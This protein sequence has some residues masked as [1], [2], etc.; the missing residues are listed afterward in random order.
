MQGHHSP[1]HS[2]HSQFK[3]RHY[4]TKE[5]KDNLKD[6]LMAGASNW[7]LLQTCYVDYH[8]TDCIVLLCGCSNSL[9][10]A[11]RAGSC[12]AHPATAFRNASCCQGNV[13]AGPAARLE[14]SRSAHGRGPR[15]G[16]AFQ[17]G[18][19]RPSHLAS[20]HRRPRTSQGHRRRHQ[21]FQA[22]CLCRLFQT[23]QWEAPH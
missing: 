1:S 14:F 17:P 21:H 15:L 12:R 2:R 18:T 16:L 23:E 6:R 19:R 5:E 7:D 20:S 4:I 10:G 22:E 8:T 11:R 3:R 9:C 13:P